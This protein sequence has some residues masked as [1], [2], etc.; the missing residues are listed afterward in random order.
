MGKFEFNADITDG[1]ISS[2][3]SKFVIHKDW[4]VNSPRYDAD[5]AIVVLKDARPFTDHIQPICLPFT[6]TEYVTETGSAVF[7][8]TSNNTKTEIQ[9]QFEIPSA[10]ASHCYTLY[11]D[12]AFISSPNIF[13]AG[14]ENQ[15]K[16]AP[17]LGDAGG[18]FYV[19]G[20]DKSWTIMGVTTGS[21]KSPYRNC[22]ITS[23][24]L[25]INVYKYSSW[26]Y[27]TMAEN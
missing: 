20:Q 26:I 9:T 11:Y 10:N 7:W 19:L 5:L 12:L 1:S 25:Y 8:R 24:M 3:V 13:C 22:E 2:I 17:C 21:L 14:Y 23:F 18:G 6:P 27:K 16:T 15:P 4:D